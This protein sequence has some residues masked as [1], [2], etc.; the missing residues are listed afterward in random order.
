MAECPLWFCEGP[1]LACAAG[2]TCPLELASAST[3][4]NGRSRPSASGIDSS[5]GPGSMLVRALPTTAASALGVILATNEGWNFAHLPIWLIAFALGVVAAGLSAVLIRPASWTTY[6]IV[7]VASLT[8]A[9][10]LYG[11]SVSFSR[12]SLVAREIAGAS[13]EWPAPRTTAAVEIAV[14]PGTLVSLNN[15]AYAFS[16]KGILLAITPQ[17][18]ATP[19]TRRRFAHPFALVPCQGAL[20]VSYARGRVARLS[21]TTGRVEKTARIDADDDLYVSCDQPFLYAA[22][23]YSG[24]AYRLGDHTLTPYS[25][26]FAVGRSV[27]GLVATHGLLFALDGPRLNA[28]DTATMIDGE[29]PIVSAVDGISDPGEMV[30][31]GGTLWVTQMGTGCVNRVQVVRVERF[32]P[33]FRA[34]AGMQHI[35]ADSAHVYAIDESSGAL[36][37]FDADSPAASPPYVTLAQRPSDA[38]VADGW[39]YLADRESGMIDVLELDVLTGWARHPPAQSP[40][41]CS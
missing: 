35:V 2:P 15:V 24:T 16:K 22:G 23:R 1:P 6:L 5:R 32:G 30:L 21:P 17:G 9:L 41:D 26:G 25:P 40:A 34:Q 28:V 18:R 11:P 33:A 27:R 29:T 4:R 37:T 36:T 3:T 14:V 10:A 8:P 38:A 13:T 19:V 31:A 20:A 12:A 39:L 7:G